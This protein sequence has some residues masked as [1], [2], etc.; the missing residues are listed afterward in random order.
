MVFG[1]FVCGACLYPPG[2]LHLS[3]PTGREEFYDASERIENTG[4]VVMCRMGTPRA[5]KRTVYT[6]PKTVNLGA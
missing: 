1:S 4:M 2:L 6:S 5:S 3:G